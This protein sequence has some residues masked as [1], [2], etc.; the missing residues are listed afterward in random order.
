ME[1]AVKAPV[2]FQQRTGLSLSILVTVTV[3]ERMADWGMRSLLILYMVDA[4]RGGLGLDRQFAFKIYQYFT[5]GILVTSLLGALLT[6][7]VLGRRKAVGLG[8]LVVVLGLFLLAVPMLSTLYLSLALVAVGLGLFRPAVYSMI[9]SLY[10]RLDYR[11]DGAFTLLVMCINTGAMLAP[12]LYGSLADWLGWSWGLGVAA[13]TVGI[14]I[15]LFWL[16]RS[17]VDGEVGSATESVSHEA[18]A[19]QGAGI[20]AVGRT[21]IL[22]LLLLAALVGSFTFFTQNVGSALVETADSLG[23]WAALRQGGGI[24]SL[25]FLAPI[26][27]LAWTALGSKGK[28]FH[29]THKMGVG[30]AVITASVLVLSLGSTLD[31]PINTLVAV[32]CG[33]LLQ[34]VGE[35]LLAP[36]ALA[37]ITRLAPVR[38]MALSIA[39]WWFLTS[40][41]LRLSSAA[42]DL[43]AQ[44]GRS[45]AMAIVAT[46]F[47]PAAVLMLTPL[48]LRS[49]RLLGW[50]ALFEHRQKDVLE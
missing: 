16:T 12:L 50:M 41:P 20:I 22:F 30:M 10:E 36:I 23:H 35:L 33:V 11:R 14:G 31:S 24:V 7:A 48:L 17:L 6:D 44:L 29:R 34:S 2:S 26:F 43:A 9:G 18:P 5:G 37:T 15:T 49:R 40:L 38:H 42:D 27:S 19:L 3:L 21:K 28:D 39:G 4:A 13:V 8:G 47:I 46:G 32:A 45:G 1:S 25:L